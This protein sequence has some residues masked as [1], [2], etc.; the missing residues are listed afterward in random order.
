MDASTS[1]QREELDGL[2]A[3]IVRRDRRAFARLYELTRARLYGTALR[4]LRRTDLAEEVLHDAYIKI[5]S[6][7]AMYRSGSGSPLGWM[8]TITRHLALDRL[9]RLGREVGLEPGEDGDDPLERLTEP[10]MPVAEGLAGFGRRRLRECL[11]QLE[12]EPRRCIVL[13]FVDGFSHDELVT[14]LGRPLGT[15]KSWI[16]RGLLELR[17][18]LGA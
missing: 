1:E 2:V 3:R 17:E 11:E 4:L 13:A 6:S 9:R 15:V 5:W 7:A 18:C 16:R 10:V 14:R 12:A 8:I